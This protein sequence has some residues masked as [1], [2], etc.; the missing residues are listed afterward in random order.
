M[1]A[2]NSSLND[3]EVY[4]SFMQQSGG[5]VSPPFLGC[6]LICMVQNGFVTSTFKTTGWRRGQRGM[7]PC[8]LKIWVFEVITPPHILLSRTC[9]PHQDLREAERRPPVP[10]PCTVSFFIYSYIIFNCV[11]IPVLLISYY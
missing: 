7:C 5:V 11:G 3:L 4:F 8:L 2:Y 6:I 10:S 1:A 9:I